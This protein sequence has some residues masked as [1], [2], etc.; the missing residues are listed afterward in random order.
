M[1]RTHAADYL[2]YPDGK[3]IVRNVLDHWILSF[4][5]RIAGGGHGFIQYNLFHC[6]ANYCVVMLTLPAGSHI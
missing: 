5:D 1:T 6:L 4:Y 2:H 3:H